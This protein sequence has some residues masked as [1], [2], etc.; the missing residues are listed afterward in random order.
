M[1]KVLLTAVFAA[2]VIPAFAQIRPATVPDASS[3]AAILGMA[4][5][6]LA[7]FSFKRRK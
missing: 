4:C 6:T 3:T 7:L 5:G 1:K 2:T